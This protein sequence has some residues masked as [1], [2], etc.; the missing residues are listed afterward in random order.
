[1][2]DA[3]MRPF[4]LISGKR[5]G[6]GSVVH[7]MTS[8]LGHELFLVREGV[9]EVEFDGDR[10]EVGPGSAAYVASKTLY[11]VRNAGT[12]WTRYFVLLLGRPPRPIHGNPTD[13]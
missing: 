9:L 1:M 13:S 3:D 2:L 12:R 10:W 7:D 6:K 11:A 8:H 4:R 5:L